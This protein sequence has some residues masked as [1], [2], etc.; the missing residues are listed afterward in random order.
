MIQFT[1]DYV[2]AFLVAMSKCPARTIQGKSGLFGAPSLGIQLIVVGSA[3][4][5]E[6]EAED[7]SAPATRRQREVNASLSSV[8][9]LLLV[10]NLRA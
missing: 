4:W 10:W 9:Y 1:V 3:W 7:H 2:I 6:C 5:Q 8:L